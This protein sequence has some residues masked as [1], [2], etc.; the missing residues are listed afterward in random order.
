MRLFHTDRSAL[1]LRPVPRLPL[2]K[3]SL[4]RAPRERPAVFCGGPRAGPVRGGGGPDRPPEF[5]AG[6]SPG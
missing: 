2:A 4:P 5:A 1:P 6:P 3:L